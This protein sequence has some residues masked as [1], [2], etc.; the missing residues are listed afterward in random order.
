MESIKPLFCNDCHH[1]ISA[2]N[3]HNG[4]CQK[5][6]KD[7]IPLSKFYKDFQKLQEKLRSDTEITSILEKTQNVID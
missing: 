6:S 3:H 7:Q 2:N 4:K 5:R 1:V